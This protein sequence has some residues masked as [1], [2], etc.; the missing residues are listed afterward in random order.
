MTTK[1]SW[2]D[3]YDKFMDSLPSRVSEKP[4]E[5]PREVRD[6]IKEILAEQARENEEQILKEFREKFVDS[7]SIKEAKTPLFNNRE[8]VTG[9]EQFWLTKLREAEMRG[10]DK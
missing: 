2:E 3:R 8:S 6:F 7:I 10:G 5:I 4:K 9:V 1:Q